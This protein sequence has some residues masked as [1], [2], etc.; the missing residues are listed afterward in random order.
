[1]K[2]LITIA[3]AGALTLAAGAAQAQLSSKKGPIDISADHSSADNNTH[4]A[5]YEGKV[6]ALQNDNRLRTDLLHIY[7]KQAAGGAKT[8][9]DPAASSWG[10][11][12]HLEAVGNVYFVTPTQVIRGD[13]A[14]YTQDSD[15]I[16]VTGQVVMTQGENVMRGSRLVYDHKTGKSTMDADTQTGRVRTV[17]YPDKKNN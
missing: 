16:V 17:L 11:I 4:T 6:E 1:M 7:F 12:D 3:I 9:S 10:N 2:R 8:S 5:T 14:V 15:T 13:H